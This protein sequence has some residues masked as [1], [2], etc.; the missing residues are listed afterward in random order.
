MTTPTN[1]ASIRTPDEHPTRRPRAPN[2]GASVGW[3]AMEAPAAARE[4]VEMV[5]AGPSQVIPVG[6][7][8]PRRVIEDATSKD[9]DGLLNS[10]RPTG[11]GE[12]ATKRGTTSRPGRKRSGPLEIQNPPGFFAYKNRLQEQ[13][14]FTTETLKSLRRAEIAVWLAIHNCQVRGSARIGYAR[15]MEI[16]GLSKRHV[17]EA[18]RDL[19]SRGLLEVL[20]KG[21][22]RPNGG[23][24][25]G[26][27]SIYR[28]YPRPEPRLLG[29]EAPSSSDSDQ[30][31]PG[32]PK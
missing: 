16:S 31:R 24:E 18:I 5:R 32:K 13:S 2:Q 26:L 30:R 12:Q 25:H 11:N 17:G 21:K 28:V 29:V 19:E 6:Q 7:E 4:T 23:A 3:S 14:I 27:A 9:A 1:D 15:I 22:Y 8:P 20:F 10:T